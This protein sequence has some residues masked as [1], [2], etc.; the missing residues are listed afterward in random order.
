ML[1]GAA[2]IRRNPYEASARSR[3][4]LAMLLVLPVEVFAAPGPAAD[5]LAVWPQD[6]R[7]ALAGH[8]GVTPPSETTWVE[9]VAAVRGRVELE[10]R[11]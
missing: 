1:G 2:V 5:C 9:F 11:T 6:D 4:V 7:V 8:A 3:K 10:V